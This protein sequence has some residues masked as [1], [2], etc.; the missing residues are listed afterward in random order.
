M[1]KCNVF[2]VIGVVVAVLAALAGAAYAVYALVYRKRLC[3]EE[4]YEF[5][6]DGCDEDCSACPMGFDDEE[7]DAS[8]AEEP[9]GD[10]ADGE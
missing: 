10:E 2:T 7:D 8:E 1:K 3:C 4:T 5:D 9:A 6:C